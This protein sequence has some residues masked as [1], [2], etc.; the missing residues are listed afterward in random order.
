[1]AAKTMKTTAW[2]VPLKLSSSPPSADSVR[3]GERGEDH[4][5]QIKE[6][7]GQVDAEQATG[8]KT[9]QWT[10]LLNWVRLPTKADKT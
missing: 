8:D 3:A 4:Q 1:M 10:A 7:Y 2:M 5:R 6:L 9:T